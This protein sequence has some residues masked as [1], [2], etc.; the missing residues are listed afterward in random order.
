MVIFKETTVPIEHLEFH[1]QNPSV[2]HIPNS[3]YASTND[4]RGSHLLHQHASLK[5]VTLGSTNAHI[6]LQIAEDGKTLKLQ[7]L[8]LGK[9]SGLTLGAYSARPSS[10]A[11]HLVFSSYIIPDVFIQQDTTHQTL[12]CWVLTS[13]EDLHRF[14]LPAIDQL[15]LFSPLHSNHSVQHLTSLSGR[16]PMSLKPVNSNAIAVACQDGAIVHISMQTPNRIIGHTVDPHL[17]E[18]QE[19]VLNKS[20]SGKRSSSIFDNFKHFVGQGDVHPPSSTQSEE[21]SPQ[22]VHSISHAVNGDWIIVLLQNG[23][24]QMLPTQPAYDRKPLNIDWQDGLSENESTLLERSRCFMHSHTIDDNRFQI[25]VLIA[26]KEAPIIYSFIVSLAVRQPV[27]ES[28]WTKKI[29]TSIDGEIVGFMSQKDTINGSDQTALWVLWNEDSE[30]EINYCLVDTADVNCGRWRKVDVQFDRTLPNEISVQQFVQSAALESSMP[31]ARSLYSHMRLSTLA[32]KVAFKEFVNS[33]S[34]DS[35]LLD[36]GSDD[37]LTNVSD[38]IS[39]KF[40]DTPTS[41]DTKRE[42]RRFIDLC[43]HW[44]AKLHVPVSLQT[45]G[46][47]DKTPIVLKNGGI[48][49]LR[50][51]DDLEILQCYSNQRGGGQLVVSTVELEQGE[52]QHPQMADVIARTSVLKVLDSVAHLIQAFPPLAMQQVDE[53]FLDILKKPI[54]DTIDTFAQELYQVALQ[55]T[56]STMEDGDMQVS[57]FLA[58]WKECPNASEAVSWLLEQFAVAEADS[59]MEQDDDLTAR[60]SNFLEQLIISTFKEIISSRYELARNIM[61]ALVLIFAANKSETHLTNGSN[62]LAF[63][64][65]TATSPALMQW[66][67]EHSSSTEENTTPSSSALLQSRPNNLLHLLVE[68]YAQVKVEQTSTLVDL[69]TNGGYNLIQSLGIFKRTTQVMTTIDM[70]RFANMLEVYG[71]T[72]TAFGFASMLNAG[73]GVFYIMG[74]CTIKNNKISESVEYFERAAAGLVGSVSSDDESY[75]PQLLPSE[76]VH[77]GLWHYYHHV[78]EMF[79][80]RNLVEQAIHFESL[81]LQS[82]D[83]KTQMVSTT[84]MLQRNLFQHKL[85]LG[86]FE[87]AYSLLM[88]TSDEQGKAE[89]ARQLVFVLCQK[90]EDKLLCKLGFDNFQTEVKNSLTKLAEIS[91]IEEMRRYWKLLYSYAVFRRDFSTGAFAMYMYAKRLDFSLVDRDT[92]V[93]QVRGYLVAK[94]TLALLSSID[95]HI[96]VTIPNALNNAQT[97]KV[98]SVRVGDIDKEL[99]IAKARLAASEASMGSDTQPIQ[100]TDAF[101]TYIAEK[102][103]DDAFYVAQLFSLDTKPIFEA[104]ITHCI[105]NMKSQHH[106]REA[107]WQPLKEYLETMPQDQNYKY[108]DFCLV[109]ILDFAGTDLPWWLVQRYEKYDAEA[110]IRSYLR[111]GDCERAT[112][113]MIRRINKQNDHI[114]VSPATSS[115][116]MPYTLIDSILKDLQTDIQ[117]VNDNAKQRRMQRLQAQLEG[118]LNTYFETIRRET[119]MLVNKPS[120]ERAKRLRV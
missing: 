28:G 39:Q 65:A 53:V 93:E 8:P 95:A 15:H 41:D 79:S 23:K 38:F 24:L 83:S 111:Y 64:V 43:I 78:A 103:W 99:I 3:N 10:K 91:D 113:L 48:S 63:S 66:T 27:W 87:E 94:N 19:T 114:Q 30:A 18:L 20:S 85:E 96:S 32:T 9:H 34:P 80:S 104:I 12:V 52:L 59:M 119:H 115:R 62:L 67:I 57:Q 82:L 68:M 42:W 110:L 61:I 71:Y 116:W 51:S 89:Q 35:M 7:I 106:N 2:I 14:Q 21:A 101:A 49:I 5:P 81:A 29:T 108:Y 117:N 55:P 46:P 11:L 72:Q 100:I 92:L 70:V 33:A 45:A 77:D 107:A 31:H 98:I 109:K 44:E 40:R 50:R 120:V 17:R 76:V 37:I 74:K 90:K 69:A 112:T 88:T 16:S 75:L 54:R 86:A 58:E 56:L 1:A 73:P 47:T 102:K 13:N 22:V 118:A 26:T 97:P 36:T 105:Y 84:V 25:L 4:L 60:P 6:L